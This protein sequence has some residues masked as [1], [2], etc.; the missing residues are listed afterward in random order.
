MCAEGVDG[1]RC[2]FKY[3]RAWVIVTTMHLLN[4]FLLFCPT[5]ERYLMQSSNAP[6]NCGFTRWVDPSPIHPHQEYIY[7]LQNCIFDLEREVSSFY[8]DEAEDDNGN[9]ADSQEAPCTDPYCNFPCHTKNMPPPP[10]PPAMGGYCGEGSTQFAMW[11]N[12]QEYCILFTCCIHV[13]VVR[14]NYLRHVRFS[15]EP[16]QPLFG[17][18]LHMP[19]HVL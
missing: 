9:S 10:P 8:P 15:P 13:F 14:F 18:G 19:P 4:I 17:R 11:D 7:Y 3:P 2:F 1:G 5:Y 12:Y 6:E 16:C